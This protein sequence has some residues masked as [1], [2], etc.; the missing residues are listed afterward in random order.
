ME[1]QDSTGNL[2]RHVK[3]CDP[4][5]TAETEMISAYASGATY[6]PGRL[7][8]LVAMWCARRHRPFA[9]VDDPEFQEIAR[10]LYSK[11]K[12]PSHWTVSRDVQAIFNSTKPRVRDH[13]KVCELS[14]IALH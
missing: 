13:L 5:E 11:A 9:I 14:W 6:S 4:E 2:S 3:G 8:F 10:M 1:Y 7:R 12:I